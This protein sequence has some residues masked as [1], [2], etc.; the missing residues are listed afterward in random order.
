[1]DRRC[2]RKTS[3]AA[4]QSSKIV[5]QITRHRER[6]ADIVCRDGLRPTRVARG[7]QGNGY[8]IPRTIEAEHVGIPQ[9]QQQ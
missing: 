6:G 7:I 3:M 2:E 9:F 1:M 8:I 4:S 5:Q